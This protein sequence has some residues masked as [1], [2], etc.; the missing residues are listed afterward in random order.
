MWWFKLYPFLLVPC[1]TIAGLFT[2]SFTRGR[3]PQDRELLQNFV[4]ALVMLLMITAG[5]SRTEFVRTRWDEGYQARLAYM[6]MP[7]HVALR[8]HRP[9]DWAQLEKVAVT[10]FDGLV[11]PEAVLTQ[12]R[13]HYLGLARRM[14]DATTGSALIAYAQALVP[15]LEHLQ[16]ADPK[17]CVRM[18]LHHVTGEPFDVAPR[19]PVAV[20]DAWERAVAQLV[21]QNSGSAKNGAT[22]KPQPS[23]AVEEVRAALAD[24]SEP[25]RTRHGLLPEELFSPAVARFDPAAACGA[26]TEMIRRVLAHEP[27]LARTLL[28]H[29]LKPA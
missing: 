1:A 22:W 27:V 7:V 9:D 25:M 16:S 24:M 6:A 11:P 19:L 14:M 29:M 18:A 26:S 5:L 10:A 15:V 21:A 4:V 2:W 23:A 17:L 3:K 8:E 28:S 20:N 12:T 13:M